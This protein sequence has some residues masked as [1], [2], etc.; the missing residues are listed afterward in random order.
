MCVYVYICQVYIYIWI[1]R[2]HTFIVYT[3]TISECAHPMLWPGKQ[4]CVEEALWLAVRIFQSLQKTYKFCRC[5]FEN[6]IFMNTLPLIFFRGPTCLW[7]RA[8]RLPRVVFPNSLLLLP[9]LSSSSSARQ[10]SCQL[11]SSRLMTQNASFY[12]KPAHNL[13]KTK[14][15]Q[16]KTN[17]Q[18]QTKQKQSNKTNKKQNKNNKQQ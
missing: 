15:Q 4:G 18:K 11:R 8:R 5:V 14:S 10:L 6:Q 13:K 12:W 1:Q 3:L 17:Q 9:S 16:K 7:R 2:N